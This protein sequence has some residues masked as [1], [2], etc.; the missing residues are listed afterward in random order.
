[1]AFTWDPFVFIVSESDLKH[2][3]VNEDLLWFTVTKFLFTGSNVQNNLNLANVF[4]RIEWELIL[5]IDCPPLK[6]K[7]TSDF[8]LSLI[9]DKNFLNNFPNRDQHYFYI[10][11]KNKPE[12]RITCVAHMIHNIFILHPAEGKTPFTFLTFLGFVDPYGAHFS[13]RFKRLVW[14]EGIT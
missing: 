11:N 5:K 6:K 2:I 4:V 10:K 8:F 1:M 3:H 14:K 7:L 12:F 9:T 13:K